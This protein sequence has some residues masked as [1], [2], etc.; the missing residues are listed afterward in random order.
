MRKNCY[1]SLMLELIMPVFF[2]MMQIFFFLSIG[3][4]LRKFSKFPDSFFSSLGKLVVQVT[5]PLYFI[6]RMAQ[7]DLAALIRAIR[8]PL[9]SLGVFSIATFLGWALFSISKEKSETKS[10]GIAMSG[11]GNAGYLPI[12]IV[13]L[14]PASLPIITSIFNTELAL[15]YIGAFLFFYSPL[16]WTFGQIY[17]KGGSLKGIRKGIISPPMIGIII[18]VLLAAT[19][20][21]NWFT[22]PGNILGA[23]FPAIQRIGDMTIPLVLIV[24]G[25]MAGGLVINRNNLK[26]LLLMTCRVSFIRF[27]IMPAIFFLFMFFW[28]SDIWTPTEQWVVFLQFTTPPATNLSIM[29][30]DSRVRQDLVP[31]V[32]IVTYIIFLLV[33]PIYLTLFFHA[34]DI[35]IV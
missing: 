3:F 10:I 5:V 32:L 15:F 6:A 2:T 19:G 33:F 8:F 30:S 9:L 23:I 22:M 28:R 18:G 21:G 20:I 25:S 31:F 4:F 1:N 12:S 16:L 7:T 34:F 24:L 35:A 29:A 27:L 26:E 14:M 11:I 13:E 17:M